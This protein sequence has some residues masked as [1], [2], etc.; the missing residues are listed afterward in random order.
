MCCHHRLRLIKLLTLDKLESAKDVLSS[1]SS[2][3]KIVNESKE[4]AQREN[5][6]V[7]F[8]IEEGT[9]DSE[10]AA[11]LFDDLVP[12]RKLSRYITYVMRLGGSQNKPR[13]LRV[14][15]NNPYVFSV[16]VRQLKVKVKGN[17]SIQE[18]FLKEG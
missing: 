12:P 13:P 18:H 11:K 15:F 7:V 17:G 14:V 10:A 9:S 2:F 5:N 3:D 1:S 8:G 4:R 6:V 16:I